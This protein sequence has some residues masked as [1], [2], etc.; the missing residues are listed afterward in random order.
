MVSAATVTA[1]LSPLLMCSAVASN[2]DL[3]PRDTTGT[4]NFDHALVMRTGL[5]VN[6]DGAA[7]SYTPGDHGFTYISNGVNLIGADGEKIGC[8]ATENNAICRAAWAKAEA[9]DFAS[10]T[11]MFCTFALSVVAFDA[12]VA[13]RHCE[14]D[15]SRYVVGNGQ[16]RPER[17]PPVMRVDGVSVRP[18]RS[19]TSLRHTVNGI[20]VYIDSAQVPALVVPRDRGDLIGSVAWVRY[21]GHA[22]FAIVNDTGPAFGEG[23]VALHLILRDRALGKAQPIGP[24]SVGARCSDVEQLK[25][26]FVSRP[27]GGKPDRCRPGYTPKTSADIRAYQGIDRDVDSVILVN[28]KPRMIGHLASIEL[29]PA[30]LE[31]VAAAAGYDV[32]KLTS[33]ANCL[34]KSVISR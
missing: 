3:C 14:N 21:N 23:S 28:V 26:P 30:S 27:D 34:N 13:L 6:P 1:I 4:L 11:P 16:G 29:S 7:A 25:P 15:R 20:P 31:A 5:A 10:G 12:G 8:S 33:F 19:T 2:S 17:G 18:Y 9:G 24:I 32:P 22:T